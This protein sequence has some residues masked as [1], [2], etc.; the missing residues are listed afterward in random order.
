ML[1]FFHAKLRDFEEYLG[2]HLKMNGILIWQ[3]SMSLTIHTPS[4]LNY[5]FS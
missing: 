2:L 3:Q 1:L 5:S 4:K